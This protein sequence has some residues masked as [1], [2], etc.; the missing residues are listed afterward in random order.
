MITVSKC[1]YEQPFGY[2][3]IGDSLTEQVGYR[4]IKQQIEAFAVANDNLLRYR[5]NQ[6]GD[7]DIHD[8]DVSSFE[9]ITEVFEAQRILK[10]K[11]AR[12]AEENEKMKKDDS[13]SAQPAQAES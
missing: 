5:Y 9:D 10:D 3:S 6:R 4:T 13:V 12:K 8:V 1:N 11:L 7:A 2:L